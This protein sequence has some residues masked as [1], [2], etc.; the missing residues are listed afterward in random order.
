MVLA[1]DLETA[2]TEVLFSSRL[3]QTQI[4]VDNISN[5][6][7]SVK[8]VRSGAERCVTDLFAVA[9]S[10]RRGERQRPRRPH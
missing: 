5:E 7:G 4:N 10:R 6:V 9:A 2:L 8:N 1:E 3:I